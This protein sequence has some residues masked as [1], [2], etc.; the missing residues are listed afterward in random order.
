LAVPSA[1]E[2]SLWRAALAPSFRRAASS[3]CVLDVFFLICN[4]ASHCNILQLTAIHCI[5]LH[6]TASHCNA[7]QRTATHCSILQLTA[8][9]CIALRHTAIHCN[10]MQ[11]TATHCYTLQ[12]TA[13]HN[14]QYVVCRRDPKGSQQ[15]RRGVSFDH[16][17]YLHHTIH[18]NTRKKR[19]ATHLLLISS[20]GITQHTA[21]HAA[22]H[23]N[24]RCSTLQHMCTRT[25]FRSCTWS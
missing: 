14:V 20:L 23:S 24:T 18:C 9:D 6:H 15:E 5:T 3:W 13:R 8:S 22:T 19:T 12:H 17:F 4:A 2:P 7:L 21:T 25:M 11:H 1:S 16:L 10:T